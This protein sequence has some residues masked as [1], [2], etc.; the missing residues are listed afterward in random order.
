MLSL[1]TIMP[2][3]RHL[4][5]SAAALGLV[6]VGVPR[7]GHAQSTGAASQFVGE[8]GK[9]LMGVVNSG[10]STQ[11]KQSQLIALV[12]QRVDVNEIAQFCLGTF[13]RKATPAQQQD[14]VTLFHRVLFNNITRRIGDYRGVTFVLGRAS[15]QGAD[16]AVAT[17]VTRPGNAPNQVQWVVSTASGQPKIIDVKA[18]GT[19]LRQ[20]QRADY[21]SF[22]QSHGGNVAAFLQ[23]LH[24]QAATAG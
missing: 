13:W 22:L 14:Y 23:A 16:T 17:T 20:T 18:E 6:M 2:T 3:R 11:E 4:L 21:Y 9:M 12:D 10:A 5:L 1:G 15:P 19:S 8:T 7:H 24:R